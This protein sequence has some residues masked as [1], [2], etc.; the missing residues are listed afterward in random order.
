LPC[1]KKGS[2]NDLGTVWSFTSSEHIRGTRSE[3]TGVRERLHSWVYFVYRP[4]D[5]LKTHSKPNILYIWNKSTHK[6]YY[7]T[8]RLSSLNTFFVLGTVMDLER[9]IRANMVLTFYGLYNILE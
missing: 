4:R 8:K 9:V 6:A 7:S 2:Q 1:E 5:V 3:D